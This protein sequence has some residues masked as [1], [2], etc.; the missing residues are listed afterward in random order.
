M[1]AFYFSVNDVFHCWTIFIFVP[2][3]CNKS[4]FKSSQ[5]SL[6]RCVC[7]KLTHTMSF[8]MC[9]PVCICVSMCVFQCQVI[10]SVVHANKLTLDQFQQLSLFCSSLNQT[11]PGPLT[12]CY[13]RTI[14]YFPGPVWCLFKETQPEPRPGPSTIPVETVQLCAPQHFLCDVSPQPHIYILNPFVEQPGSST[15]VMLQQNW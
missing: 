15:A 14:Q 7:M 2:K 3:W 8:S 10:C 6:S 9:A 13:S 4:V 12:L 11:N 1:P 5:V